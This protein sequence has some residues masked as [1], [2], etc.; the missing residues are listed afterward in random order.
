MRNVTVFGEHPSKESNFKGTKTK[1]FSS[2]KF[3]GL[4]RRRYQI[5]IT[6]TGNERSNA[7]AAEKHGY[8]CED[9]LARACWR[10]L[11]CMCVHENEKD[12]DEREGNRLAAWSGEDLC[13]GG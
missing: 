7:S 6:L 5:S 1:S 8:T 9:D 3:E 4:R 10:V 2:S 13:K 11:V 12:H